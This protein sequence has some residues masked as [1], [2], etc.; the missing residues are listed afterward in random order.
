MNINKTTTTTTTT[1]KEPHSA[2]EENRQQSFFR[3]LL[4][5]LCWLFRRDQQE[6]MGYGSSYESLN[7]TTKQYSSSS[8]NYHVRGNNNNNKRAVLCGVTY[9][10]KRKFMLKGTVN[11][12]KEMRDLLINQYQ[13]LPQNIRVLTVVQSYYIFNKL[14]LNANFESGLG[15]QSRSRFGSGSG[16]WG[17][18]FGSE[19]GPGTGPGS[20]SEYESRVWGTGSESGSRVHV[21]GPSQEYENNKEFKPTK[22][23]I[24]YWLK[25]LVKDCKAGD[26]LVFYFSGH[27]LRQPD[28]KGDELDGFDETICPVDFV[29]NG[30]IFDNDINT[31]I[32]RPLPTGVK[33]HAIV[34]ACHSG[35]ILDLQY[36]YD[37]KKKNWEDHTPPS[38][39]LKCTNGGWALCLSACE[40]HQLA[41]DTTA[42]TGK[43]MNGATTYVLI[44]ILKK[45]PNIT[46]GD[47]LDAL[48]DIFEQ[49]LADQIKCFN[50]RRLARL[51]GNK[52][53]QDYLHNAATKFRNVVTNMIN[54]NTALGG[55]NGYY[56]PQ[57]TPAPV[58][59]APPRPSPR[60]GL[61]SGSSFGRR[62]AVLCGVS[63]IGQKQHCKGSV[64]DVSYMKYFLVEKMRFPSDCLLI[65]TGSRAGDSLVFFYSGHGSRQQD[66]D[67]DEADGVDETL[68]PTDYETAG[69]IV[70]DEINATIVRPLPYGATL[71]AII[72]A[73]YSGTVLDL[74]FVCRMNRDGFYKW[75][76]QRNQSI[77]K[78]TK[79][80]V[81]VSISACDDHQTSAD[82]DALTGGNALA[83]AMTYSFI[84]A[85]QS[86]PGLT[87]G[88]LM[89]AMRN[90]IREAQ[91]GIRLNGPIAALVNKILR[92]QL[93]QV[94][95]L[96]SSE[97]F[98]IYS[99]RF[100]I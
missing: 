82:T 48:S 38:K 93:S 32:V 20:G 37:I 39:A 74:P 81:A 72:D 61:G 78:G 9:S 41:A 83:G 77:Y 45:N 24:E 66:K 62:R 1:T 30:M 71:H 7:Y 87:Y 34:D 27:G 84:L 90:T 17:S 25:W 14:D 19:L 46:Y 73:C 53:N 100:M 59:V 55:Y 33:L 64:N 94:P 76:D 97:E 96:S 65:L 58:A 26:S 50:S 68:C 35:T 44:D 95:Q 52:I 23:N 8:S 67:H 49:S 85:V 56:N 13:Y 99:K 92:T 21:S 69:K 47:L 36:V 5:E 15:P 57:M 75:E 18:G 29:E 63:Y 42:F 22:S 54:V 2:C 91:T 43:T 11:D 89:T 88:R 10:H 51:F 28:F 70:D 80:G 16:A 31:M 3:E 40:D 12:V 4:S 6:K 98:D 86:E 60:P 79:G